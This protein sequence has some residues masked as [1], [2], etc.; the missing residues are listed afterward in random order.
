MTSRTGKHSI[1][2]F[3]WGEGGPAPLADSLGAS[4]S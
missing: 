1:K 4:E 3:E 2:L